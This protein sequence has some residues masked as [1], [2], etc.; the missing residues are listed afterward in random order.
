MKGIRYRPSMNEN[1]ILTVLLTLLTGGFN[2]QSNYF[3]TELPNQ[4]PQ[5]PEEEISGEERAPRSYYGRHNIPD[6]HEEKNFPDLVDLE[7]LDS[8]GRF[9]SQTSIRRERSTKGR[10]GSGSRQKG[11]SLSEWGSVLDSAGNEYSEQYIG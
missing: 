8:A 11:D 1:R 10:K 6:R 2:S 4:N 7:G 5:S 3:A 9:S